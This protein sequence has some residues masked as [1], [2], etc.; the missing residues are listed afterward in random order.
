MQEDQEL[1][2]AA[3]DKAEDQEPVEVKEGQPPTQLQNE[4]DPL[5]IT[6]N[7]ELDQEEIPL[8][9][10]KKTEPA[11]KDA[12]FTSDSDRLSQKEDI[13]ENRDGKEQTPYPDMTF[14]IT[15]ANEIP[16]LLED[17]DEIE[18]PT[19][20]YR[21]LEDSNPNYE[22][23]TEN[24]MRDETNV[25]GQLLTHHLD[26]QK[27]KITKKDAAFAVVAGGVAS[28]ATLFFWDPA[29]HFADNWVEEFF[30]LSS[31]LV[32]NFGINFFTAHTA[33][34]SLVDRI[35]DIDIRSAINPNYAKYRCPK[36]LVYIPITAL[37]VGGSLVY[38]V[39]EK[40]PVKLSLILVSNTFM[41]IYTLNELIRKQASAAFFRLSRKFAP[42]QHAYG[43][44]REAFNYSVRSIMD[45]IIKENAVPIEF[46][47]V[48]THEEMLKALA[49]KAIEYRIQPKAPMSNLWFGLTRV[50]PFPAA[51]ATAAGLF[52]YLYNVYM[53]F[54][55]LDD[56][57]AIPITSAVSI[58][59][60]WAI[61]SFSV[62]AWWGLA[63]YLS[64]FITGEY[65]GSLLH[66]LH[67]KVALAAQGVTFA[68][69][70]GSFATIA[71]F[72]TN[73][74]L[75]KEGQPLHDAFYPILGWACS[76]AII[77]NFYPNQKLTSK[78][79]EMYIRRYGSKKEVANCA[80]AI[81][82]FLESVNKSM[83]REVFV[84]SFECLDEVEKSALLP[85][86]SMANGTAVTLLK[87]AK[88]GIVE[89]P[90]SKYY[91][92]VN[93]FSDRTLGFLGDYFQNNPVVDA[94]EMSLQDAISKS[95]KTYGAVSQ[96][97]QT[98]VLNDDNKPGV[99]DKILRCCPRLSFFWSSNSSSS[100]FM[101][102]VL[103]PDSSIAPLG[104]GASE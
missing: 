68:A 89:Q 99:W 81:E 42:K 16:P 7:P 64:S 49:Q 78:A 12:S 102:P 4:I 72:I 38:I 71:D 33:L 18:T 2:E 94:R 22:I 55:K 23:D 60:Q 85:I 66:K 30:Y 65:D 43:L 90:Y 3:E 32:A 21:R 52:I 25:M 5:R 91:D 82:E 14:S 56:R 31:T 59:F 24:P 79:I 26:E 74:E 76:A 96:S 104:Y 40:D 37:A 17:G 86:Y 15:D 63:D 48:K 34:S 73:S 9:P 47:A 1:V 80:G 51:M 27:P 61:L 87:Q 11:Q 54:S 41:N 97:E 35:S 53:S 44:L 70:A 75:F 6:T 93:A 36:A 8:I 101:E 28:C 57:Y 98:V 10:D 100:H 62:K 29:S 95:R 46:T 19:L 45:E 83:S 50:L 88:K 69:I 103:D 13:V 77:I 58:I 20:A 67:P 84:D 39:A 92:R